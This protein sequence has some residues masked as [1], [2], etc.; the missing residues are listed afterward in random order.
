MLYSTITAYLGFKPNEGEYKVMGLA[1]YGDPTKYTEKLG[2]LINH[3]S[4]KFFINQ[5][6]FTW[7]YSD[8]VMFNKYLCYTLG[9]LPRLPNEPITQVHKDLAASL[10]KVYEVEFQRLLNTAK[11][12]TKSPNLCLGG[13]CAYNGVAN[14]LA[15]KFFDSVHIPYAPSDAGSS[16]GACLYNYK[17]PDCHLQP[18]Q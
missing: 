9:I 1:P 14:V 17:Y 5:K 7:E 10:Q 3:T 11:N 6:P 8:K 4:N 16:I 2:S 15:Y 13:G 12:F 18:A